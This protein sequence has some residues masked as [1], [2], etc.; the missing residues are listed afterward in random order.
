MIDNTPNKFPLSI[1]ILSPRHH[2]YR[3]LRGRLCHV[4]SVHELGGILQKGSILPN[5]DGSLGLNGLKGPT[6]YYACQKLHSISLLD[7]KNSEEAELFGHLPFQNWAGM[8]IHHR[9]TIVLVFNE[10][11]DDSEARMLTFDEMQRIGGRH[12]LEAEACYPKPI[13]IAFIDSAIV[14]TRRLRIA[15]ESKDLHGVH[16]YC[17]RNRHRFQNRKNYFEDFLERKR[18]T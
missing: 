1:D 2:L 14:L 17:C 9:P 10:D 8:F 18:R 4:T 16:S 5:L 12:I 3:R 13:P 15:L 11:F 7:L 6:D